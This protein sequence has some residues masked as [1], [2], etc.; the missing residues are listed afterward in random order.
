MLSIGGLIIFGFLDNITWLIEKVAIILSVPIL[1]LIFYYAIYFS[2]K[3]FLL[4]R[5][6]HPSDK[7]LPLLVDNRLLFAMHVMSLI[8][9]HARQEQDGSWLTH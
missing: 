6:I 8:K 3:F 1:G 2:A 5:K 7:D 4:H 9:S